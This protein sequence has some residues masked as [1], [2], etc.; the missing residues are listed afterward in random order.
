MRGTCALGRLAAA[1]ALVLLGVAPASAYLIEVTTAVPL[2]DTQ[3]QDAVR[4]TLL[5]AVQDIL[6]KAIAFPPAL[7]VLTGA[8]IVDTR[9]YIRL[10]VGDEEGRQ[11]FEAQE[12]PEESGAELR[13]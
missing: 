8:T 12:T 3:D 2:N 4:R 13:I 10:L 1:A 11:A 7:V 6:T 5:A 9:L